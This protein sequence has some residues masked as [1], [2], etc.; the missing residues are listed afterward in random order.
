MNNKKVDEIRELTTESR[1][2]LK[3]S[4]ENNNDKSSNK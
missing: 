4:S 2:S 3:K 1:P